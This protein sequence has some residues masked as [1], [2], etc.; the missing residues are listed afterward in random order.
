MPFWDG[1]QWYHWT[2]KE[3]GSLLEL[4]ILDVVS[5][6]YVAKTSAAPYDFWV[7]FIELCWQRMNWPEIYPLISALCDDFQNLGTTVAKLRHF[8][9]QKEIIPKDS[10]ASFVAT[11]LEYLIVTARTIF[12][13]LQEAISKIWNGRIRL[14][15]E[16]ANAVKKQSKM[17]STFSKMVFEN[18]SEIRGEQQLIDRYAV[19]ASLALAYS[20]HA[21]FFATLRNTRDKII[22]GG[23]SDFST[24][25]VTEKGFCVSPRT[26]AFSKY[27]CWHDAQWYNKNIASILPWLAHVVFTTIEA[28]NDITS[29]FASQL[30]LPEEIAPG[31]RVFI[32][33]HTRSAF[34][35]L[36]KVRNGELVWWGDTE[37]R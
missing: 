28:C 13:L 7:Q 6:H 12:D 18:K 9:D 26:P 29:A 16:Q 19:T 1:E 11:E 34:L 22:H 20:K 15:D 4:K 30:Q 35:D 2:P 25:F 36:Q 3:D 27:G 5:S 8:F 14:L 32:R 10:I 21:Q 33:D 23:R 31:Y 24:I 37:D 17:P